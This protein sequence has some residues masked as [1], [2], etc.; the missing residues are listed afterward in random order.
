MQFCPTM[1]IASL[2]ATV[3]PGNIDQ[4]YKPSCY[5]Y[6]HTLLH[7]KGSKEFT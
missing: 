3:E 2:I 6:N 7:E 4:E 5:Q 1:L